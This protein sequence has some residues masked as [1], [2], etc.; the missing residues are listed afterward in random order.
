[1]KDLEK[2]ID[3]NV[4]DYSVDKSGGGIAIIGHFGGEESFVDGQTLKTKI[5][6]EELI[7]ATNWDVIKVD[8]YYKNR[9]VKLFMDFLKASLYVKDIIILLSGNGMRIFFPLLYFCSSVLN[10]NIYHDV[11]GGNLSTYV[12]KNPKYRKYLNS[13]RVN[14]VETDYLKQQ[15][16]DVGINNASVI[17]NFRRVKLI[18]PDYLQQH[19]KKPYRFCTFSRVAKEKGI[20][21]A[22]DA[23]E[24]INANIQE[25]LCELDI[26]G[27][28]ES[29]YKV[30]FKEKLSN[31]TDAIKYCGTV[32]PEV[33]VETLKKYYATLFA[34]YWDGESNAGTV[35]ESQAAGVPVI[36]TDWH[37]NKEMIESGVDGVIYPGE[38]GNTLEEAILWMIKRNET[39]SS[40]Q[41]GNIVEIKK[42]ARKR[43]EKYKPDKWIKKIIEFIEI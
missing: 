17:P 42:N 9:P 5:L 10:K 11:I 30:S 31:T 39:E 27:P 41:P 35:T 3:Q 26:Y 34:T 18:N 12:I 29:T 1:M 8:T 6:Y 2:L 4:I 23:I 40:G 22:I 13:F 19:Y 24:S 15:L 7:S 28:I 20:E 14:W 16:I 25:K 36:A 37:C 32:S 33:A 21:E 43:A 38:E